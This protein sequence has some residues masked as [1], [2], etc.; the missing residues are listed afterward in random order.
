MPRV[1]RKRCGS[2]TALSARLLYDRHEAPRSDPTGAGGVHHDGVGCAGGRSATRTRGT[3]CR[4][5]IRKDSHPRLLVAQRPVR[6]LRLHLGAAV[7]S[8][9]AGE[10]WQ[11]IREGLSALHGDVRGEQSTMTAIRRMLDARTRRLALVLDGLHFVG[12]GDHGTMTA[13]DDA[14]VELV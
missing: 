3:A 2:L 9:R 10:L 7:G 8:D 6:R 12:H 5:R 14:L 1:G 4:P 11:A 13:V